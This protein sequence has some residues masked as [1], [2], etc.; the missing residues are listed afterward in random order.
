MMIVEDIKKDL[1]THLKKYRRNPRKEIWNNRSKH[2]KQNTRDGRKN[3]RYR[4][5]HR[6][7]GHNNQRKCK[8]KK[9]PNSK[10]P[11]NPGHNEKT[12]LTD[13]RSR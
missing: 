1:I 9:G 11:G 7:H 5:C 10:Y 2:Q 6:E 13:N 8:M 4:R 3:L 12:K